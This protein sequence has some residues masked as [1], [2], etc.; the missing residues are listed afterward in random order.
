MVQK[1]DKEEEEVTLGATA[2]PSHAEAVEAFD[3]YNAMAQKI[4][5]PI[6]RTL[7]PQR[8]RSILARL[9]DHGG[10]EAW[11]LAL[12]NIERSAFLRGNNDRGWTASFDFLIQPSR[13]TKVLEGGYGNGAAKISVRMSAGVAGDQDELQRNLERARI[14]DEENNAH[15]R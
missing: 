8:K 4:G 11:K 3:L 10:L 1:P 5:I 7:T 14:I 13:F 15:R 2:P 9:R 12:A 6:A